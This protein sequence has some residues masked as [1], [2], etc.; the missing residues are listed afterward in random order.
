MVLGK[1]PGWPIRLNEVASLRLLFNI[2]FCT[3]QCLWDAVALRMFIIIL[4]QAHLRT[5]LCI[6]CFL[7]FFPFSPSFKV[8]VLVH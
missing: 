3:G 8:I 4:S 5:Y 2:D 6:F 1:L 7:I